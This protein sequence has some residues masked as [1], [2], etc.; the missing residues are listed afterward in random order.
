MRYIELSNPNVGIIT[1][2]QEPFHYALYINHNDPLIEDYETT[3]GSTRSRVRQDARFWLNEN[4]PMAHRVHPDQRMIVF[5]S[6]EDAMMFK[7]IFG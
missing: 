7:L 4:L 1:E 3:R 2:K 6:S 5:R